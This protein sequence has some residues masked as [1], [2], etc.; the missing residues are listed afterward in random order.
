MKEI[1]IHGNLLKKSFFEIDR[2]VRRS[3]YIYLWFI[4]GLSGPSFLEMALSVN[5]HYTTALL[6][7]VY[8]SFVIQLVCLKYLPSVFSEFIQYLPIV[9]IFIGLYSIFNLLKGEPFS[10][11]TFS[12]I[13][14]AIVSLW[15]LRYILQLRR[16]ALKIGSNQD[17]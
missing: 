7:F 5:S 3:I 16:Y 8:F 17:S 15:S 12:S 4:I 11:Y 2:K 10:I 14:C 6:S 13:S 9:I 1:F